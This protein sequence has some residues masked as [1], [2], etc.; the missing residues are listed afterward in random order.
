MDVPEAFALQPSQRAPQL[1][2]LIADHMRAEVS[3]RPGTIPLLAKL[4]REVED[5]G[6]WQNVELASKSNQW[7]A[8]VRLHIGGVDGRKPPQGQPLAGNEVKN[9]EGIAGDSLVV[10]AVGN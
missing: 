4:L 9:L 2:R 6:N 3:V 7:L 1:L 5:K 10:L 8:R